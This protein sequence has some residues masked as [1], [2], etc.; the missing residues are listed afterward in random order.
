MRHLARNGGGITVA[1]S[2]PGS[3]HLP[4]GITAERSSLGG[5]IVKLNG[6][7]VGWMHENGRQWKAVIRVRIPGTTAYT[8]RPLGSWPQA[9][10]AMRIARAA[11]WRPPEEPQPPDQDPGARADWTIQ[12][13]PFT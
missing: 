4:G 1:P 2:S 12:R 11:G 13:Q 8:G 3:G 7:F 9:E 5:L 10:A 6:R